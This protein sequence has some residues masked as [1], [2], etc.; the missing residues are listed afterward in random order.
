MLNH[1]K[2][3]FSTE[4]IHNIHISCDIYMKIT[5]MSCL[6]TP[7]SECLTTPNYKLFQNGRGVTFTFMILA[8]S[9]LYFGSLI[10]KNNFTN[11]Y[12]FF[13]GQTKIFNFTKWKAKKT[14]E[15]QKKNF[16]HIHAMRLHRSNAAEK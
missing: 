10:Y 7:Y 4:R 2:H 15:H 9:L 5:K 6:T 3:S 14:F 13:H 8:N 11:T 16:F 12:D 1:V